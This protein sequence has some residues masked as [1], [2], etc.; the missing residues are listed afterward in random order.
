MC[1]TLCTIAFSLETEAS[2]LLE[3]CLKIPY[4]FILVELQCIWLFPI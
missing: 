4:Y 3:A 1:Y 2:Q